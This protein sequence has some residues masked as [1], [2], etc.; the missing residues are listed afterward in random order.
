MASHFHT[1]RNSAGIVHVILCLCASCNSAIMVCMP[2]IGTVGITVFSIVQMRLCFRTS[3]YTA[4]AVAVLSDLCAA[5]NSASSVYM[6]S[7]HCAVRHS[8]IMVCVSVIGTVGITVYSVVQMRFCFRT[9]C[10]IAYAMAVLP[11]LRA[12]VNSAKTV[13]VRFCLC[14]SWDFAE[15]CLLNCLCCFLVLCLHRVC[16]FCRLCCAFD[17]YG[18][19]IY[20]I[21]RND[22]A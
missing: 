6:G 14:T 10:Y 1:T 16:N 12:A 22:T 20:P 9:S 17:F 4:Y 11:D 18:T 2:V 13:L 7:F 8:A 3:C 21:N 19:V 15:K 5:V